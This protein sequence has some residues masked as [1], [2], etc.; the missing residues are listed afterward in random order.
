[1]ATVTETSTP[2]RIETSLFVVEDFKDAHG[3]EWHAGDRASLT[4]AAVRRAAIE[5]PQLFRVE[6]ATEELDPTA[7]WFQEITETHEARYAEAKRQRD[8]AEEQRQK[9]LREELKQQEKGQPNLERRYREQEREREQRAQ[10]AR[11]AFEREKVERDLE[12]AI[13]PP[14]FHN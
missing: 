3:H 14:G 2:R 12:A 13:G 6:W 1:M 5:R 8:G 9:A 11:E 4:R 10:R 7:P